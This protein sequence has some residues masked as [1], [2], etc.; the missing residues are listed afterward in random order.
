[1]REHPQLQLKKA[2]D[3]YEKGLMETAKELFQDLILSE[4]KSISSEAFFFLGNIFHR[5]G[6]VGKAI[7]AFNKV[8][9]VD[10][11]HTDASVSLSVLYNDI[12]HYES[13]KKVYDRASEKI[14]TSSDRFDDKHINRKFSSK[15]F[16]LAELYMSYNRYDEA[17]FEYEKASKLD[18]SNLDIRVKIAKVYAKK[19]FINKAFEELKTL[20]NEHP[21]F[22]PARMALGVLY[23]GNGQV[24]QAQTEWEKVLAKNPMNDE[25]AMYMNLSK[26]ATETRI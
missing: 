7:K 23:Y 15:H 4:E 5:E 14:K 8:L 19:N 26:T 2:K 25:A 12:G 9:E 18:D 22:V 20:K 11:N 16:E 21:S 10:P 3:M 1:M 24:I 17:L 6:E 13:A